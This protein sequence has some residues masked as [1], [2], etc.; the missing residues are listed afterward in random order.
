[1]QL[2]KDKIV[3]IIGVIA[4]VILILYTAIGCTA[5]QKQML[6]DGFVSLGDCAIL[7]SLGCA[8]QSMGGCPPPLTSWNGDDWGG[9]GE[10]LA[11]KSLACASMAM[12]KCAYRSIVDATEGPVI[13]GGVGCTGPKK[14]SE[15][16]ACVRD[17]EYET[18]AE[19]VTAVAACQRLICLNLED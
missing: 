18:E 10:C 11:E 14:Q 1:M 19:A 12:A 5:M 7:S 3:F 16:L 15:I 17:S 13:Y 4:V 2:L 8:S 6:K 9:Y